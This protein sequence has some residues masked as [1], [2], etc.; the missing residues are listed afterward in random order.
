MQC[1]EH[2]Y[3]KGTCERSPKSGRGPV[4]FSEPQV[5][6]G[7]MYTEMASVESITGWINKQYPLAVHASS[8]QF[9]SH[10]LPDLFT[11]PPLLPSCPQP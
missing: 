3:I 4:S 7:P 5:E 10:W 9:R 1:N 8:D 6:T 2:K 11:A